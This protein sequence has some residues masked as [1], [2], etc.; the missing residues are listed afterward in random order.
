MTENLGKMAAAMETH[1]EDQKLRV[2][3]ARELLEWF[4]AKAPLYHVLEVP[5][6]WGSNYT[7][8][9]ILPDIVSM[10]CFKCEFETTNWQARSGGLTMDGGLDQIVYACRNCDANRVTIYFAWQSDGDKARFEKVGRRPKP[11]ID[12]PKDLAQALGEHGNFYRKGMTLRHYN[13]GL[14]SLVYFRR[15]L[16]TFS[17]K[18]SRR[19]I[20]TA[21][22][23][24]SLKKPKRQRGLKTRLRSPPMRFRYNFG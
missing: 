9:S 18:R 3:Q 8:C 21:N 11:E 7:T 17:R 24:H 16:L 15:I 1:R 5:V 13:F 22:S 14:G 6:V 20:Q 19:S 2:R 23:W 12:P 10:P 4:I